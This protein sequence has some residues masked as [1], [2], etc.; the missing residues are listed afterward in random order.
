MAAGTAVA[1]AVVIAAIVTYLV[2]RDQLVGQVDDALKAQANAVINQ[3]ALALGGVGFG[4]LPPN[5]GGPAPYAQ[6]VATDGSRIVV[7][8]GLQLP[9]DGATK[10]VAAGRQATAIE[11][12]TAGGGHLRL[13][14]FHD[15]ARN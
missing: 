14:A 11:N 6:L 5:A 1:V 13:L 9:V 10:A 8:G 3:G 2:V 15:V 4:D 12:V 7:H